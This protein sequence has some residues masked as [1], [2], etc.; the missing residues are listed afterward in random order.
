MVKIKVCPGHSSLVKDFFSSH[1]LLP[2]SGLKE[3]FSFIFC[4]LCAH[5]H[6]NNEEIWKTQLCNG[7]SSHD[8]KQVNNRYISAKEVYHLT[9]NYWL[10]GKSIFSWLLLHIPQ[11][12]KVS[13]VQKLG[14]KNQCWFKIFN[15]MHLISSL[16]VWQI[17][18]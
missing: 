13:T 9:A 1:V 8:L 10:G 7:V 6:K 18:V 17:Y 2:I 15:I 5:M 14:V 11:R 3:I 12:L 4:K 16:P